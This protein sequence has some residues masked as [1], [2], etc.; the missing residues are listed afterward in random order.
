M[1]VKEEVTLPTQ[2]TCIRCNF[3]SSQEVCKA[4]VLL[5]GLNKG[6]PKL[7]IGKTSKAK[8]MLEE[9]NAKQSEKLEQAVKDLDVTNDRKNSSCCASSR[10]NC[11]NK[12]TNGATENSDNNKKCDTNCAGTCSSMARSDKVS[13][14]SSSKINTLLQQ[15]GIE[16]SANERLKDKNAE[17]VTDDV[18][19]LDNEDEVL[20]NGETDENTCAG[21][22]GSINIGF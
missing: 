19:I 20:Y 14:V 2:R 11:R 15:Y 13:E 8:K 1:A 12:I 18:E 7:G 22:C 9:Y 17:P 10:G 5:E 4:C 16:D 3:V 6:L 21:A